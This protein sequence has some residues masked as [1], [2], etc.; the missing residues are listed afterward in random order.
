MT[1]DTPPGLEGVPVSCYSGSFRTWAFD[2]D[3]MA[4]F[5]DEIGES[6]FDDEFA[7]EECNVEGTPKPEHFNIDTSP[8][9]NTSMRSS[10]DG[11]TFAEIGVQT[12]TMLSIN[13]ADVTWTPTCTSVG[14]GHLTRGGSRKAS[15]LFVGNRT[16]Q[17]SRWNCPWCVGYFVASITIDL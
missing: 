15:Q 5:E 9:R 16:G 4:E 6:G 11:R 12:E 7:D 1:Q 17:N 13:S 10:F 14:I 2:N 3:L 8:D